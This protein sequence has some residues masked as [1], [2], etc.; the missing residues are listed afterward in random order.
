MERVTEILLGNLVS[1][2]EY[3]TLREEERESNKES[4]SVSFIDNE[5]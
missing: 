1:K 4:R 2:G 3:K 5:P